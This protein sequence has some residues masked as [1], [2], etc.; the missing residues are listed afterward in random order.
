MDKYSTARSNC[1]I[2]L[3]NQERHIFVTFLIAQEFSKI[4]HINII[5]IGIKY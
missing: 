1:I 4:S 2:M 5:I 3:V